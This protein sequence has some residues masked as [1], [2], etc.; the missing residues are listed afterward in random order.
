MT[1]RKWQIGGTRKA[2]HGG[3]EIAEPMPQFTK[4]QGLGP[5]V[6]AF[7]GSVVRD[8]QANNGEFD[9][10][11]DQRTAYCAKQSQFRARAGESRRAVVQNKANL[12]RGE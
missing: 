4:E 8:W 6:G 11:H 2:H 7:C 10:R 3:T 9:L 12:P 1:N 5:T